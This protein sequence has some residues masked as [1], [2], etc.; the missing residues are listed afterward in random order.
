MRKGGAGV[1]PV[2]LRL[3]LRSYG[4]PRHAFAAK[5][6]VG[7]S[8]LYQGE[9]EVAS[10]CSLEAAQFVALK[11]LLVMEADIEAKRAEVDHNMKVLGKWLESDDDSNLLSWVIP[12]RPGMCSSPTKTP[13]RYGESGQ[14]IPREAKARIL[15]WVQRIREEK[16][17]SIICFMHDRGS[18]ATA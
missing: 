10:A 16:I 7:M 14:P 9:Q 6:I 17:A 15:E 3:N 1:E 13:P 8:P 11:S 12:R 18:H 4:D 2:P 5:A